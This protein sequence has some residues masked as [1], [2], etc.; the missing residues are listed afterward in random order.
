MAPP[1]A[2][3]APAPVVQETPEAPAKKFAPTPGV[4]LPAFTF[5]TMDGKAVMVQIN[6]ENLSTT[7]SL[8]S[9]TASFKAEAY[10]L[11]DTWPPDGAKYIARTEHADAPASWAELYV[12]DRPERLA[13]IATLRKGECLLVVKGMLAGES[14]G[15]PL[16]LYVEGYRFIDYTPLVTP[17]GDDASRF[18]R[19]LWFERISDQ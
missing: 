6:G 2:T 14:I 8:W 19:T 13:Q 17:D 5:R 11:G 10:K 3:K 16:R 18:A 7:P 1:P 4:H 9:I 15:G 12:I